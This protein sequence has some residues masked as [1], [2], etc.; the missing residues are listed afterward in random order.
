MSNKTFYYSDLFKKIANEQKVLLNKATT[1][2][3]MTYV[4]SLVVFFILETERKQG[5]GYEVNQKDVE[6]YLSL[7]SSTITHIII[8]MEK[9]GF[10]TRVR[11]LHDSRVN[12]L[13][14]TEKGK[15]LVPLFFQAL[16]NVESKMTEGMTGT[17]KEQL[18][19]LLQKVA[20]NLIEKKE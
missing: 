11:S 15:S 12:H 16:D 6:R 13:S 7:K 4:Q 9:N 3:G 18:K 17:E 2:H 19:Q 10:L 20:F 14:V 5:S 8:R 1:E